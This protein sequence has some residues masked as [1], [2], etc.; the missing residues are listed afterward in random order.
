M[1]FA[2]SPESCPSWPGT[3]TRIIRLDP[4]HGPRFADHKVSDEMIEARWIDGQS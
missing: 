4:A 3:R 1:L 2:F